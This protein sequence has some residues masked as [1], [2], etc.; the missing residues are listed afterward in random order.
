MA[1]EPKAIFSF[2]A[3]AAKELVAVAARR[4]ASNSE[5]TGFRICVIGVSDR[6]HRR[7]DAGLIRAV[8]RLGL[9]RRVERELF[10]VADG[11]LREHGEKHIAVL[12]VRLPGGAPVGKIVPR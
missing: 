1:L 8:K 4:S 11:V 12:F 3:S 9:A 7:G 10:L 6:F 2:G 5:K